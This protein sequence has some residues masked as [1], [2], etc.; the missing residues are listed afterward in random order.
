MQS[1]TVCALAAVLVCTALNCLLMD[2]VMQVV[3]A[4][5]FDIQ[6]GSELAGEESLD[7]LN[8]LC[9]L[10][11]P[12]QVRLCFYARLTSVAAVHHGLLGPALHRELLRELRTP[13]LQAGLVV[14]LYHPSF[15]CLMLRRFGPYSCSSSSSCTTASPSPSPSPT[16]GIQV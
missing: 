11:A 6:V 9:Q 12:R 10:I 2:C 16:G 5:D 4:A 3:A 1:L 13:E 7:R 15:T 14:K 8:L